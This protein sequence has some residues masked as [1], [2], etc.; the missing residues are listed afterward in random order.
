MVV[1]G[2]SKV[3]YERK[4]DKEYLRSMLSR[5]IYQ[6]VLWPVRLKKKKERIWTGAVNIMHASRAGDL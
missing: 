6:A 4:G 5:I 1:P 2:S 3:T